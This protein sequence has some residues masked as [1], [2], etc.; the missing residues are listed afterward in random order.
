MVVEAVPEGRYVEVGSG[1]TMHYHDAG[2]G[3]RVEGAV[4]GADDRVDPGPLAEVEA[5]LLLVD[6]EEHE[7]TIAA[8]AT[9]PAPT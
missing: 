8:M 4:S 5:H 7:Y 3:E 9:R 6:I 2:S 1:I